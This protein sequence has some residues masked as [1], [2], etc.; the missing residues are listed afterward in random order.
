VFV[1]GIEIQPTGMHFNVPIQVELRG[2]SGAQPTMPVQVKSDTLRDTLLLQPGIVVVQPIVNPESVH[3]TSAHTIAF[4]FREA[5]S[6]AIVDRQHWPEWI[7]CSA[8]DRA[9]TVEWAKACKACGRKTVEIGNIDYQVGEC[10]VEQEIIRTTFHDCPGSPVEETPY[11]EV[12]PEC[13]EVELNEDILN[14]RPGKTWRFKL[15]RKRVS[16]P[17]TQ[18]NHRCVG[19]QT[20]NLTLNGE[21]TILPEEDSNGYQ[22]MKG[23]GSLIFSAA[24][25][26]CVI[27][28]EY[29][30]KELVSGSLS[31]PVE[32]SGKLHWHSPIERPGGSISIRIRSDL[33]ESAD[34]ISTSER[35]WICREQ[36][37]VPHD[38]NWDSWHDS[39]TPLLYERN[40]ILQLSKEFIPYT[41]E[42][43]YAFSEHPWPV[44]EFM[45]LG[46][47]NPTS[48]SGPPPHRY[49][50]KFS[51]DVDH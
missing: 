16:P 7:D 29:E 45:I 19:E 14:Y 49:A 20:V 33:E 30:R 39:K 46:S 11:F 50:D 41:I 34:S 31:V 12:T 43:S 26:G 2:L 24:E 42:R 48:W 4:Q 36:F 17:S 37:P 10:V 47:P 38:C 9:D 25:K 5:S 51:L 8:V 6:H 32:V 21:L 35:V 22:M 18:V 40:I 1:G 28:E 13:G 27:N 15:H 23:N 44:T 3:P